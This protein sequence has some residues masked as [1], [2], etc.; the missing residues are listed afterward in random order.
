MG[1][2]E[3]YGRDRE[4]ADDNVMRRRKVSV[5]MMDNWGKNIVSH[6]LSI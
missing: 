1:R 6:T 5:C 3:K 2:H 4:A